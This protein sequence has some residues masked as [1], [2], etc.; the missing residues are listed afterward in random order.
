MDRQRQRDWDAK[1]YT[2]ISCRISKSDA[3]ELRWKL[4]TF[5]FTRYTFF[6]ML[7][8]WVISGKADSLLR[9]MENVYAGNAT[10]AQLTAELDGIVRGLAHPYYPPRA[11]RAT[12]PSRLHEG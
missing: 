11:S 5:H 7:C 2:T 6:R 1:N 3:E 8:K 9:V 12:Q 4:A 10:E